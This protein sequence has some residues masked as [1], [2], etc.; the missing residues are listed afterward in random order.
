MAEIFDTGLGQ[1]LFMDD[2]GTLVRI[3][4]VPESVKETLRKM[5]RPLEPMAEL[6]DGVIHYPDGRTKPLDVD[7][8]L[9]EIEGSKTQDSK[10]R[11]F[12]KRVFGR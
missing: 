7:G 8:G 11:R 2:D 10:A 1:Q 9:D 3:G 12:V 6:V 5:G 4:A